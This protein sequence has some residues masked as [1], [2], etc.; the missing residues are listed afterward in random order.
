MTDSK[1]NKPKYTIEFVPGCFD[2]FD[3]T[4]EELDELI[5]AIHESA[6]SGELF[7]DMTPIDIDKLTEEELEILHRLEKTFD[8]MDE[9]SKQTADTE[10]KRKL[11]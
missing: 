3:G 4:Q 11:N 9:D 2:D 5:T 8:D 10:R 7:E 1:N 6:A